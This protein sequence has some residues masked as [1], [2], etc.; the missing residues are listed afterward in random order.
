[1]SI[2]L[3]EVRELLKNGLEC[4]M[5]ALPT[6][7][8]LTGYGEDAAPIEQVINPR[9]RPGYVEGIAENAKMATGVLGMMIT[10]TGVETLSKTPVI[11]N[12]DDDH[13]AHIAA[14]KDGLQRID[15]GMDTNLIA[16]ATAIQNHLKEHY[17]WIQRNRVLLGGAGEAKTRDVT[18]H[19]RQGEAEARVR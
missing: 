6:A 15:L 8:G 12:Q 14:H 18:E 2:D 16:F 5:T 3:Q 10:V 9:E 1:M 19:Y 11:A 17:D 4:R 7:S 13:E